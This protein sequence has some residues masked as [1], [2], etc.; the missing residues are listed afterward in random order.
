[1][2]L[3]TALSCSPS[4]PGSR[5]DAILGEWAVG[6]GGRGTDK[7]GATLQFFKDG[8]LN[9]IEHGV[10]NLARY[11]FLSPEDISVLEGST[12]TILKVTIRADELAIT[13][14]DGKVVKA[15][16]VK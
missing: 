7:T 13:R 11:S 2:L 16:R 6:E 3:T 10:Q 4:T 15:R 12:R 14:P 9:R 5:E 8:T 1:L